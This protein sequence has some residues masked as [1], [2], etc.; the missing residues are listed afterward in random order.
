MSILILFLAL[1]CEHVTKVRL[2]SIAQENVKS[3]GKSVVLPETI[4]LM[5]L[6]LGLFPVFGKPK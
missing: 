3:A 4:A 6:H 2:C 1:A 5:K